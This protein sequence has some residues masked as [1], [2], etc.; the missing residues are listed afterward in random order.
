MLTPIKTFIETHHLIPYDA[1]IIIGL[2]GGPDSV[3]LLHF[4]HHIAKERNLKLIAAHLDH[5]WRPESGKDVI[6]CALLSKQ[7]N[8]P[9]VSKRASEINVDP[10]WTGSKEEMGRILRRSFFEQLLKEYKADLI[11]LGQHEQ[12]QQETFFIRLIRGTTLSGL[13]GMRPKS[14][15]YIRL[16]LETSKKEIVQYLE[17]HKIPYLTDPTNV[18]DSFLRNCI[19][20]N[21]I[22]ELVA[23]DQRFDANFG[24]T[25]EALVQAEDYLE[26][27][28]KTT[29]E[30]IAQMQ[31]NIWYLNTD[32]LKKLHP[33]LQN[34][35]LLYWLIQSKVPFTPSATLLTEITRFIENKKSN[36]HQLYGAWTIRK[37]NQSLFIIA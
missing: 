34:R 5:E 1:T 25:H 22:P 30:S 33:Y 9:F 2:S 11:A 15:P 4:L 31:D 24:R 6:F 10:K 7:L 16:L 35:V 29:F 3:F 27:V 20:L 14:G 19:R 12:D 17:S 37:K 21:V 26:M 23:C 36:Q 13:I 28:T 18:S 8:I 32:N